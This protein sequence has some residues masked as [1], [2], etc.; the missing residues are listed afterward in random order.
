MNGTNPTLYYEKGYKYQTYY[1]YTIQTQMFGFSVEAYWYKLT[2][3]GIL[4]IRR[5][6]AWDGAS[7]PTIDTEDT[8]INSLIHDVFYQMMRE[9]QLPEDPC[10]HIANNELKRIGIRSGMWT[11]RANMWKNA[12]EKFGSSSAAVQPD[13]VLIAN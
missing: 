5:G 2:P 1:D 11:W 13:K 12:V 8:I 3:D 4:W 7:G 9:G 10:F 6:Y